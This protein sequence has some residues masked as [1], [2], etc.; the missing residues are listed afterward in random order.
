MS[1]CYSVMPWHSS[2]NRR[3]RARHAVCRQM[4]D[5]AGMSSNSRKQTTEPAAPRSSRQ[6]IL[7]VRRGRKRSWRSRPFIV[8]PYG[9]P[10]RR[11]ATLMRWVGNSAWS[12]RWAIGNSSPPSGRVP[13]RTSHRPHAGGDQES[14]QLPGQGRPRET[15]LSRAAVQGG[16]AGVR[17]DA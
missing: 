2:S 12:C 15:R 9:T 1:S 6:V 14:T 17:S 4:R 8:F 11:R 3:R 7:D 16:G 5:M 10:C 13:Y